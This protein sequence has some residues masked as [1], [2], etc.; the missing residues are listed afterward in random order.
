M[1][2]PGSQALAVHLVPEGQRKGWRGRDCPQLAP[3]AAL[4]WRRLFR[5]PVGCP[6]TQPPSLREPGW[7]HFL[8][9]H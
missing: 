9:R 8:A 6:L 5:A 3:S 4:Q 1:S 7:S 2:W